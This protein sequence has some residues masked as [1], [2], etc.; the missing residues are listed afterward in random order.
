MPGEAVTL[1][2]PFGRNA[3]LK[4]LPKHMI[5]RGWELDA[6][7]NERRIR[8]STKATGV[9]G[10][11]AGCNYRIGVNTEVLERCKWAFATKEDVLVDHAGV[12]SYVQDFAWEKEVKMKWSVEEAVLDVTD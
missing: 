12:G 3:T 1:E 6:D 10:L 9:D 11:E 4:P 2:R 8:R 7:G 5:Q